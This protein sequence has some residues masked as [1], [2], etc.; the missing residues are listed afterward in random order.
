V[1]ADQSTVHQW[2]QKLLGFDVIPE[3]RGTIYVDGQEMPEMNIDK[4]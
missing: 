2:L 3:E 4:N 1:Q